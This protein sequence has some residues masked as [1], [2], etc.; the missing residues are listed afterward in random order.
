MNNEYRIASFYRFQELSELESLKRLLL[1]EMEASEVFGTIII[2]EEGF[3][4]TVSAKKKKLDI[5]LQSI[6]SIFGCALEY[7]FSEHD[8]PGFRRRKIKIKKEIV[9]LRKNVRMELGHGTHVEAEEWN[10]IISDPSVIV[11]DARNDYEHEIGTFRGARNPHTE[12]FSELPEII[13]SRIDPAENPKIAMFCTSGIRCEK[14]APYLVEK[15]FEQVF[16]LHGGILRYLERIPADESLWEGECFVFDERITVDD[17]LRK[18]TAIDVSQ[19][20]QLSRKK[21]Q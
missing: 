13:D 16:Q 14:L 21:T 7:N 4:G 8:T 1:A 12:K 5:F 2:A 15:G 19:T 20:K 11:V 3:N 6:E 18:G 17:R 10:R 9:T